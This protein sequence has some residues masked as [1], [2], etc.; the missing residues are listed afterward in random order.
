M[1][2]KWGRRRDD[3]GSMLATVI[4]I[5]IGTGLCCFLCLM[6]DPRNSD[7][8][9]GCVFVFAILLLCGIVWYRYGRRDGGSL[10]FWN[11]MARN[12]PDDGLAAQYRPE[13]IKDRKPERP[14]GSNK[15][16]TAEEARELK[17][18]SSRTWVPSRARGKKK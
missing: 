13:K 12:H 8:L 14:V 16:I 2:K 3:A 9:I 11:A 5:V 18:T 17:V 7:F 15:P 6:A 10:A 4:V 1:G